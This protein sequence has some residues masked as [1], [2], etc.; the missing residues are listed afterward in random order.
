M[1]LVFLGIIIFILLISVLVNVFFLENF[2]IANKKDDL[3]YMYQELKI[4]VENDLLNDDTTKELLLQIVEKGNI[5][6]LVEDTDGQV[7][8]TTNSDQNYM[9]YQLYSYIL[10]LHDV[11]EK[12]LGESDVYQIVKSEDTKTGLEY[13]EMWGYFDDGSAFILRT[14]MESIRDSAALANRFLIYVG[15]VLLLFS[16][17]LIR[18]FA[19]R[20]TRPILKLAQLS[21]QMAQLDFDAKYVPEGDDELDVLGASFNAMSYKLEKVISELKTANNELMQDIEKKEKLETMR[22]EFLGS[23]SHELKTPI[24]LIQGYAEGLKEGIIDDEE[25][26]EFYCEVIMDEAN[27]MN[28]L[29]KNLL[30]LNQLEFGKEDISLERFDIVE[31]IAGII[32]SLD[33][34]ITQKEVKV[35]FLSDT[36][37]YVWGEQFK[38]EQVVRNY[39][40]NA[41]NHVDDKKI[42]E[43]KIQID[44]KAHISVFNTGQAIPEEDVSRIWE[45]FYKVDKARTREYGGNGIGLSIVKAI[46]ES[47]HQSYGVNNYDNGVEFWFEL[48]VK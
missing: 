6:L 13:I 17:I 34:I 19:N 7:L 38:V 32:Q 23:V 46:M 39:L 41:L 8:V 9:Q 36:P 30:E 47:M 24:A 25:S 21:T 37:I 35:L 22:T 42:I 18:Y 28:Q 14:P 43:V 29:V 12:T 3:E 48:E 45:K 40:T 16:I 4:A 11:S 10:G 2:Y 27:K 44:E 15:A 20:I 33:I 31:L 26:R 1:Y 5:D